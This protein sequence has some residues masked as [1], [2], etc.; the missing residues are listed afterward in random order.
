MFSRLILHHHD[1]I[2]V[3]VAFAV[4]LSVFLLMVW[5]ALRM[6]RAQREALAHLPFRTDTPSHHDADH[7]A[8]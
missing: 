5:R 4:A 3:I 8:S 1:A 2:F 7:T 6:P